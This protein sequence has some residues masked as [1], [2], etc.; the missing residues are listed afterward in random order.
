[1]EMIYQIS[2]TTIVGG[3]RSKTSVEVK[4]EKLE[5]SGHCNK[6]AMNLQGGSFYVEGPLACPHLSSA[7]R[8]SPKQTY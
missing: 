5:A 4:I 7:L 2:F 3:E 1:M 6:G 8:I